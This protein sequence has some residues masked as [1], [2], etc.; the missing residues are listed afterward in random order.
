MTD[1]WNEELQDKLIDWATMKKSNINA[2]L[3]GVVKTSMTRT[4][5]QS[6]SKAA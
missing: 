2:N 5:V 1:L 4:L 6:S 3:I